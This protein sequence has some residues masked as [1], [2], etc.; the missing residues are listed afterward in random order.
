LRYEG[1]QRSAKVIKSNNMSAM[2]EIAKLLATPEPPELGPGPRAGVQPQTSL[3]R[4]LDELFARGKLPVE[5]QQLIRAVILL[6]H[7]HLEAA[8]KIA[9][10]IENADG[11]FIHGIVHRREPD[12]SNARYWFQ[13]VG[14]HPAFP[15]IASRVSA[16]LEAKGE[17]DL[18]AKLIPRGVWDAVSFIDACERGSRP[19]ASDE[20]K[21]TLREIQGVESRA[22]LEWFGR[23]AQE[24][25]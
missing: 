19:A 21:Q 14:K 9:Q 16:L 25:Q 23:Q 2:D 15:E 12:Y 22:L 3:R 17:G 5:K 20:D 6:W 8:H 7:D 4:T 13:R 24:K 10:A 18:R 1:D 11:A